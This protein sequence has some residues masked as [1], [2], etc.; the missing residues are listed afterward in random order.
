MHC[1]RLHE[2]DKSDTNEAETAPD[3]KDFRAKI[4]VAW[5]GIDHI[6]S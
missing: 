2:I 5:T 4:G 3:K 1:R 6:R